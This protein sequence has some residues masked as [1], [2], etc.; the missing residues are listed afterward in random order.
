[1]GFLTDDLSL[2]A[3]A[4]Q[5]PIYKGG[6]TQYL[7]LA[8]N[9]LD[10]KSDTCMRTD[11]IGRNTPYTTTWWKVDLGAIY[12]IYSINI[13]FK[14][15]QSPGMYEKKENQS[16]SI[17]RFINFTRY[18]RVAKRFLCLI[19]EWLH[20]FIETQGFLS[21][22]HVTQPYYRKTVFSFSSWTFKFSIFPKVVVLFNF[23]SNL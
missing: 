16:P 4:S 9:A 21:E 2:K 13:M 20:R 1:M 11:A 22:T 5:W 3:V 23:K 8:S 14:K 7:Y 15:Y 17:V 19:N 18:I 6:S 10:R 12:N